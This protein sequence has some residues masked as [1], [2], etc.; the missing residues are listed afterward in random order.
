MTRHI[1][2][3]FN[4]NTSSNFLVYWRLEL[5]EFLGQ[6]SHVSRFSFQP[7][8]NCFNSASFLE[9]TLVLTIE[10]FTWTVFVLYW[11]HHSFYQ[12]PYSI[13]CVW[14]LVCPEEVALQKKHNRENLMVIMFRTRDTFFLFAPLLELKAISN[15]VA[16]CV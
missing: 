13:M 12:K 15:W 6:G 11:A 4:R 7:Y 8:S 3:K 1:D 10:K 14:I 16:K 9:N 2:R 5:L